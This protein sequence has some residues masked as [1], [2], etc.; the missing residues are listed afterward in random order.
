MKDKSENYM[1]YNLR[2]MRCIS[3]PGSTNVDC[4]QSLV[5][6]WC[7]MRK[8]VWVLHDMSLSFSLSSFLLVASSILAPWQPVLPIVCLASPLRISWS[9]FPASSQL[10]LFLPVKMSMIQQ[11][12]AP[13]VEAMHVEMDVRLDG[14][15]GE[16]DYMLWGQRLVPIMVHHYKSLF[17]GLFIHFICY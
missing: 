11:L 16:E 4:P 8:N 15:V 17:S 2:V 3:S 7:G 9:N 1:V 12:L 14:V 13:F 5:W 10:Y 6:S